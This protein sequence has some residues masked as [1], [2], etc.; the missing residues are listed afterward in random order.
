MFETN[1]AFIDA[2]DVET[3][4][5]SDVADGIRDNSIEEYINSIVNTANLLPSE[6]GHAY[7]FEAIL[8]AVNVT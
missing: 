3:R 4:F 1:I 5:E 8:E 2:T 6:A 7:I